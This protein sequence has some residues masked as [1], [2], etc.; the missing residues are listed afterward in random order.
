[1]RKENSHYEI[2]FNLSFIERLLSL[3]AESGNFIKDFSII[4]I[5]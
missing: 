2:S 1:M 5:N 3:N 4:S